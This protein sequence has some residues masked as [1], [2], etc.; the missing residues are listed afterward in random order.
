[1]SGP[2]RGAER[3]TWPHIDFASEKMAKHLVSGKISDPW[4]FKATPSIPSVSQ[5]PL[6][7]VQAVLWV[8]VTHSIEPTV[9]DVAVVH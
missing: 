7:T 6:P 1:M 3:T 9:P 2:R 4:L 5:H 8:C